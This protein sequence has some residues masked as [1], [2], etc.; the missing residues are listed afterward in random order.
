MFTSMVHIDNLAG[1]MKLF[2]RDIPDPK[3]AITDDTNLSCSV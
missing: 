3:S 1:T 2:I